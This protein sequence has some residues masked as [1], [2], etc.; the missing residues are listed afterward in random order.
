M[1]NTKLTVA[2]RYSGF[3]FNKVHSTL[4]NSH[5]HSI[6]LYFTQTK[7]AIIQI[8]D[9]WAGHLTPQDYASF[10]LPYQQQ[11]VRQVKATYP[12]IPLALCVHDS[13][14]IL[15]LMSQSGVDI[16]G[17]IPVMQ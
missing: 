8:F 4:H 13:G 1:L 15:H 10:A 14:G 6:N 2:H 11:V 17:C 16:I 5:P 12:H 3:Y 7:I 9:S